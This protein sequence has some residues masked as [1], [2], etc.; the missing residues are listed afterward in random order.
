MTAISEKTAT[1]Q[2]RPVH[3]WESGEAHRGRAIV[4]LHG[5]LGDAQLHW[6]LT[7]TQLGTE[8]QVFAPDLP[9][10]GQTPALSKMNL[11][12]LIEWL[13]GFMDSVNLRQAVVIGHSFGGLLARLFAAAHPHYVPAV[14]MLNGGSIYK[15]APA[16]RFLL[17]FPVVS[18]LLTRSLA[19]NYLAEKNLEQIIFSKEVRTAEF[20]QKARTGIPGLARLYQA[21]AS[22]LPQERQPLVP[23]LIL[24]GTEDHSAPVEDANRLKGSIPGAKLVTIAECGHLPHL[25]TPDV[26]V[27]QV[28]QFLSNLHRPTSTLPGAGLLPNLP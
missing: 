3:Y 7:M 22:D 18:G 6:H 24:W 9:G 2:G 1:V 19:N 8:F 27:W 15:P 10:F 5:G 20:T 12:A 13:R 23:V 14:V 26:F 4:L 11:N 28:E 17:N 16:A 21:L 25:E